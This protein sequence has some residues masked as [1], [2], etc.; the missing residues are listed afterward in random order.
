[1]AEKVLDL[2]NLK[3]IIIKIKLYKENKF[4]KEEFLR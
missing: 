2:F 3:D 1:M 4:H